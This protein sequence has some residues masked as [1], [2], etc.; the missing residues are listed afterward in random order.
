MPF[1][2]RYHPL[3]QKT[4]VQLVDDLDGTTAMDITPS[5]SALMG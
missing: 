4:I 1:H 5:P 2:T 3:A